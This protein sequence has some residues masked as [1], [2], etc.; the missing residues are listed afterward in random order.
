[1]TRLSPWL[2]TRRFVLEPVNKAFY[3]DMLHQQLTAIVGGGQFL[4]RKSVVNVVMTGT[5]H[6]QHPCLHLLTGIQA[7]GALV[8]VPGPGDQVMACE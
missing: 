2:E 5:A 7:S 4:F 8:V 1:M 6:P 3:L